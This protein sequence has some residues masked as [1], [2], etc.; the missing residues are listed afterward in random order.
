MP[1]WWMLAGGFLLIGWSVWRIVAS[2]KPRS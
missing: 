1:L 2:K